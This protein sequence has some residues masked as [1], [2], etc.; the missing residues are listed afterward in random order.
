MT[1]RL[2]N[3]HFSPELAAKSTIIDFTVT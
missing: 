1:S 2:A 3:P